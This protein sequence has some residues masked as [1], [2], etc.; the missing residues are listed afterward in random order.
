[1]E[2]VRNIFHVGVMLT[3]VTS[4]LTG[5]YFS[6][7]ASLNRRRPSQRWYVHTNPLN[8]VLF[9]DELLPEGLKYR[10]K[11]FRALLMTL[12]SIVVALLVG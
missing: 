12:I 6:V 7:R 10:A 3:F 8:A 9:E 4:L 2:T 1:M 11:A 5:F